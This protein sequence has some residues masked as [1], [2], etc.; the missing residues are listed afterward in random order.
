V[1]Q[2]LERLTAALSGRYRIEHPLGSGGMATV[3]LA[4]DVRH[5]REVALKVLRPE[6]AAAIG[7]E[8]FLAE[9][10]TTAGLQHPHILPLFDSGEVDGTVFYVMPLVSGESLR[11]RL[12]REKQLPIG[13]ALRIAQEVAS[14][15][16]YA[17]RRGIVHRDIKPEN[18]LLHDS[19]ALVADFGIA[20]TGGTSSA[21]R[22]TETGI[23]LGTPTYMSPE[24]A[25]GERQID[26][27]TDIYALGCV[28]FE[29]LAGE[30]PHTGPTA[31][32]VVSKVLKD[33]AR[34]LTELRKTVPVHVASAVSR[35]LEKLPA[36]RFASAHEFADAIARPDA[37]GTKGAHRGARQLRLVPIAAAMVAGLALLIAGFYAGRRAGAG[38]GTP[39]LPSRLAL[40]APALGGSGSGQL[41]RQLTFTPDGSTILYMASGDGLRASSGFFLQRLDAETATPIPGS[42]LMYSPS[43]SPDGRWLAVRNISGDLMV[44]P[45]T[46]SQTTPAPV[47]RGY[48]YYAWHPDGTLILSRPPYRNVERLVPGGSAPVP[49]LTGQDR[50]LFIEQIVDGGRSAIVVLG[51]AGSAA[52]PCALMDLE[53]GRRTMLVETAIASARYESGYLV[54]AQQ[55]G[56]LLAGRLDVRA[57]RPISNPVTLAT[58]V[59]LSGNGDAQF[60][61]GSHGKLAYIP[62][63]PRSLVFVNRDGSERLATD[64]LHNYH[65]PR[66][67]PDGGRLLIDFVAAG[68]RD[69]WVLDLQ[70]KTLSRTTFEK[71]G[72]DASWS[73]DG[74]SIVYSSLKSGNLGIYRVRPGGGDAP[75]ALFAAPS[76]N[77]TG[78]WLPD[79]SGLVTVGVDLHQGS[80]QD[81]AIARNAGK[82]PLEP[83][84]A[85]QF[86]ELYPALSRDG[87][88]LAYVSDQSGK[89]EVYVRRFDGSGEVT[90]VSQGGGDEPVWSRDGRELFYRNYSDQG[91]Q[92]TGVKLDTTAG[93]RIADR[94]PLFG[95]AN[96]VGTTPHAS[97]DVSPDGTY[98]AFVR[99]NPASRIIVLQH[100]PALARQLEGSS[101]VR[102]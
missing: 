77:F 37:I 22:L 20:L 30:P 98:F 32:S 81:L 47:A 50:G 96:Y 64:E 63:A 89:V 18:I 68:A 21:S 71:D 11:D 79:M 67:S 45:A 75:Q 14:A 24:Q 3:Y 100:F 23:S 35:A 41:H 15:L 52:G 10:K 59:S 88:W 70:Q 6:L 36:D 84:V 13:D 12:N 69:V 86:G 1:S 27:R 7:A 48:S 56:T 25:M 90:Q 43:M 85:S 76:L 94:R 78:Q 26:A 73:P 65:M 19:Q 82:G 28:L 95:V 40:L 34:P 53:S 16:D 5:D 74:K 66:F 2:T 102:P 61:L 54:Y 80:G 58:G 46:G 92:L 83:L 57:P 4:R 42:E 87:V 33:E 38:T 72:H 91:V 9:I 29:M 93:F 8:R 99:R 97:Y 39:D 62:E 55:D 44:I 31:Q 51:S 60:E 17:H 101:Q 49:L